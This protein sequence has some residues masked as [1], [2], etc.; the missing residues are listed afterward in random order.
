MF[1]DKLLTK[2][3]RLVEKKNLYLILKLL[4]FEL[5]I[6]VKFLMRKSKL[7]RYYAKTRKKFLIALKNN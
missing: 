3:V 7:T 6:T 5:L 4:I 1:Y 2:K